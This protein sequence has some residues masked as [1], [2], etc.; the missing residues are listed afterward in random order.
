[1][2]PRFK[3]VDALKL[4]DE[5]WKK[6]STFDKV[7]GKI[8]PP[9]TDSQWNTEVLFNENSLNQPPPSFVRSGGS[10]T[11]HTSKSPAHPQRDARQQ[12]FSQHQ[13]IQ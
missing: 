4:R 10:A 13:T 11:Y 7:S 3:R 2:V 6:Y 9:T 12:R 8:C 1:M 5:V